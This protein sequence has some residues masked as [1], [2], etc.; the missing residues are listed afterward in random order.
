MLGT[1]TPSYSKV[2]RDVLKRDKA[3]VIPTGSLAKNLLGLSTQ[4]P[5]KT[6]Y[7]TNGSPR[8]LQIGKLTVIFKRTSPK[9]LSSKG[10][11]STLAIQ[12]LK[13][14]KKDNVT[15]EHIEKIVTIL[16]KENPKYLAHD[17]QLAPNWIAEIMNKALPN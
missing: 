16:K 6:V 10:K 9:N 14:M 2:I 5:M 4:V 7:L 1:L 11:L 15:N 13:T 12:A 8:K 17:I 3:K